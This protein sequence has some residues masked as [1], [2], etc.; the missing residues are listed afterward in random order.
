VSTIVA[1]PA[2]EYW[3]A[4]LGR[5]GATRYAGLR[6]E[7]MGIERRIALMLTGLNKILLINGCFRSELSGE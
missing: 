7:S 5:V 2:L 4:S 1:G 3:A 6:L